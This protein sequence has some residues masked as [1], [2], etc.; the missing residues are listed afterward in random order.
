MAEAARA[1]A[2]PLH[3]GLPDEIAIWEILVRLP[4]K[5]LLR[6]RAVCRAWRLATSSRG[7]LL[8]HHGRQP[9]L[10][11]IYEYKDGVRPS[12]DIMPLEHREGVAAADQLY[13]IARLVTYMDHEACCDGLLI[14]S[15]TRSCYSYSFRFSVCNPA[16]R[17]YAP[18]PLVSGFTPLGMYPDPPTGEY[19]LLLYPD[20]HDEL[21][22]VAED[23]CY[24]SA[25]GSCLPPRHIGWPQAGAAIHGSVPVL[26][27]GS[28]H[29]H[30]EKDEGATNMI[31]VFD[32][33]A[34]LFRQMRAPA[35]PGA[36][37]LFEMDGML[38]IAG[39]N[40]AVTTIDIWMMQDYD[41][42]VWALRYRVDLPVADLTEQFGVVKSSALLV[43]SWG[44]DV[45]ILV[46]FGEW[47]VQIGI[48]GKLV[49]S[50]Y[51][52]LLGPTQLRLKQSLVPHT[53]FPA[54][55]GYLVNTWPFIS[56]ENNVVN[57]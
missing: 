43:S 22:P 47:L 24:V 9:A 8:A 52:K 6:C 30:I 54:L 25:L 29:W 38:G 11:L 2:A 4:P 49:A 31:M 13:S 36:A 10:P 33:T 34:E 42:E 48:D 28:L 35:V 18:L 15:T 44:D 40:D 3:R 26:F 16:T 1:G 32:T 46:Q 7:F 50:F 19:R 20:A 12:L 56:Q 23:A 27:H 37:D 41:S 55:E 17:Q 57:T 53:F 5:S 21:A 14:L 39:F 51:R 45:L